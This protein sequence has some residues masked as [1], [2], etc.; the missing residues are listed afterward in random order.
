MMGARSQTYSYLGRGGFKTPTP[1]QNRLT[2][3]RFPISLLKIKEIADRILLIAE[4][5]FTFSNS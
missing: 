3:G 4:Y 5:E 2:N 1:L